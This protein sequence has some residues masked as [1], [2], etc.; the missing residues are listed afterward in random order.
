MI[1]GSY[2]LYLVDVLAH[3]LFVCLLDFI[4]PFS[5]SHVCFIKA[6]VSLCTTNMSAVYWLMLSS[7]CWALSVQIKF[8][9]FLQNAEFEFFFVNCNT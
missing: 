7:I 4:E 8:P 1:K 2:F 9:L 6:N 3:F 5:M